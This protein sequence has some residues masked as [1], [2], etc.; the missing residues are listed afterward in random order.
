MLI[1][2]DTEVLPMFLNLRRMVTKGNSTSPVDPVGSP[3]VPRTVPGGKSTSGVKKH[4]ITLTLVVEMCRMIT[5]ES[6]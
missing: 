2:F 4:I 1:C 6:R 3:Q 5:G